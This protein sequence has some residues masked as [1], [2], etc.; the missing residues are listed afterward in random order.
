M[1]RNPM[2]WIVGLDLRSHS[3]G[4][5]NFATWLRAH[6]ESGAMIIDGLHVVESGLF[7][8]PDAPAHVELLGEAS[9]AAHT[10][11]RVRD[12]E[13]TFSSIDTVEAE[14]VVEA[15]L[16]AEKLA[17]TTAVIIGRRAH[18]NDRA[19]IRL[20]KVARKLLRQVEVPTFVVPPDLEQKYIG[21][22]P[23]VAAVTLDEQGVEVAHYAEQLAAA[24]GREAR[25]VHVVDSGDP[26]GMPYLPEGTW[27]D[28]HQR[29]QDTGRTALLAWRDASGLSSYTLLA[30]GQTVPKLISAARELD[31]CMI[32]C[33]SRRLSLA[34]RVWSSSVGSTLAAA[35][36]LPVGV[37]PSA[38]A[39]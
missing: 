11:V 25:L 28:I 17:I 27:D 39:E 26:V 37:V 32:V 15:L 36:H 3:H 20:G 21:G 6:D 14:D 29:Q 22:G 5:I 19:L 24:L 13:Q 10:A 7:T 31:G 2:R 34:A 8:L 12:A 35:A 1:S 4:A 23:V 9:K 33:G 18:G 30:Q 16:A 38:T